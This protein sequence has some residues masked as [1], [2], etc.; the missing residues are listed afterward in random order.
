MPAEL[1]KQLKRPTRERLSETSLHHAVFDLV[2][3][4]HLNYSMIFPA[5]NATTTLVH[6]VKVLALPSKIRHTV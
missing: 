4:F 5:P 2:C 6:F 1:T 3:S